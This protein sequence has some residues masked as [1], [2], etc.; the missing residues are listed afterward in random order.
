MATVVKLQEHGNQF[1]VI[2]DDGSR[3]LA[4]PQGQIY[5][6]D[7]NSNG[8]VSLQIFGTQLAVLYDDGTVDLGYQV[9]GS[10]LYYVHGTYIVA[11]AWV[12]PVHYRADGVTR[13]TLGD[14][15]GLRTNPFP[16]PP[17][18]FHEGQDINGGGI[19]GW[20]IVA[21][22]DGTVQRVSTSPTVSY[23]YSVQIQHLDGTGTLCAHMVASPP[24]S[25][26]Q[27]VSV[28]DVIGA[29]G[30]T[31]DATGPH[32]HYNTQSTFDMNANTNAVDPIAFMT[33]RGVPW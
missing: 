30:S 29:V 24:V 19:T 23:G 16:P 14:G 9:G 28:G 6:V 11:P 10:G 18:E 17:T 8:V 4:Y 25:V 7:S 3:V 20:P 15:Y 26:G 27:V 31:G 12:W 22:S 1:A 2:F 21:A 13:W 32:L 33:A 5:A